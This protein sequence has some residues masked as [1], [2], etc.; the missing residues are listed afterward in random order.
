MK[1]KI[2]AAVAAIAVTSLLAA[3]WAM[4]DLNACCGGLSGI[5]G[6]NCAAGVA[7]GQ[8]PCPGV[9]EPATQA[10]I[11]EPV[12]TEPVQ[13]APMQT[14]PMQTAPMQTEPVQT[15]PVKNPDDN[16]STSVRPVTVPTSQSVPPTVKTVALPTPKDVSAPDAAVQ[17]AKN[18]PA[19]TIDPA[20]PPAAPQPVDVAA[21][22]QQN[23]QQAQ[24]PQHW[25]F[26]DYDNDHHPVL[27]NP[28]GVDMT[29]RYFY[30]GDYR[31]VSVP[32]GGRVVLTTAIAGVFP[33][34]AV[35]QGYVTS[36]YF[37]GGAADPP[38]WKNVKANVTAVDT[39]LA[40]DQVTVVGH[41]DQAP[42]GQQD[43]MM[44]DGTT[45]ARGQIQQSGDGGTV[46]I[47]AT[48]STP[49]VGPWDNGGSIVNTA[50]QAAPAPANH[51]WVLDVALLV[52]AVGVLAGVATWVIKRRA[53]QP[54]GGTSEG[55]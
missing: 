7:T 32:A 26:V 5:A 50:L 2:F 55:K 10:P 41:D 20:N 17:A 30:D 8:I 4:A 19:A 46:D 18:A 15:A 14:A 52:L 53:G 44:L 13:T 39:T 29:F 6:G 24:A 16:P 28:V 37:N 45:L 33:F 49:G 51:N 25:G 21:A 34:T 22:V 40:V 47:A 23:S 11:T 12:Q 43:T 36:G 38:V 31:D 3:P 54:V 48:Q 27:Y 42:A 9:N 35:G 1:K